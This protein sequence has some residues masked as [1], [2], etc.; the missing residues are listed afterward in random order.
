VAIVGLAAQ[1][2]S[3]RHSDQNLDRHTFWQFLLD[4][5]EAYEKL[6]QE[7]L[8]QLSGDII[9]AGG[10]FL[11]GTTKF[12]NVEFGASTKD[13]ASM[14]ASTRRMIELG[15]LAILDSGIDSRG[16]K[17]GTFIA[18]TNAEHFGVEDMG[19]RGF[20]TAPNTLANRVAY[21]LNVT[22]PSLYL[23]TA[24][25]STLTAMHLAIRS[26]ES[27]DCDAAIV[28]GCQHNMNF[29]DW[30]SYTDG[31][32]LTRDDKCKPF[33]ANADGFVKGEG[34]GTVVI[35]PLE[36]AIRDNDH[37]YGVIL[38]SAINSNGARAPLHAPSGV[39]Q[40]ECIR[41]AYAQAGRDPK[42]V[43]FVELHATGTAVGDPIEANAAGEL[44]ARDDEVI[45]GS[46]KGN[47][48]HLEVSAFF[49]SLLKIC[50]V[51]EN[52]VIPPNVHLNTPNPKIMW[53]KYGL[54]V[55]TEALPLGCRSSSGKSLVSLASSGIGGSNG[56]VVLESP[57]KV[58]PPALLLSTD[59]PVLFIVG[60]LSPRA[61]QEITNSVV[62][63]LTKDRSKEALSQAV[64]HARRARQ[65]PW[66]SYFICNPGS[67]MPPQIEGPVLIPK[68]RPPVAFVFTGQGPQH[69]GM[70]RHLF[71][72]YPVFRASILEMDEVYKAVT[73]VS[74]IETT[75]LFDDRY[76]T[77]LPAVWSVDI[78]IPAMTIMQIALFDLMISV[79]VKPDILVGHS[80][81]ETPMIY[82]S[83]AGSK[84]MAVEISIARGKAMKLTEPLGAGMAAVAC[85]VGRATVLIEQVKREEEGVL[86][87]ACHNSPDAIVVSGSNHL[88]DKAI[89]LAQD[90]GMFARKVQTLNP[91]HTSLMD[92]CRSE[93]EAGM[94]DIFQ[95]YAGSHKPVLPCYST[96][97]G[98]GRFIDEF[99]PEYCWS[100]VR[101]PVHFHQSISSILQDH[102]TAIFVEV[103]P[104]PTLSSYIVS[105]G[106]PSNMVT[107]PM[108]RPSK[109]SSGLHLDLIAFAESLGVMSTLG[110]NS[111]DLTS[112]YGRASRDPT[113]EIPYPFTT[114]HFPLRFD[115]PREPQT[116]VNGST[117]SLRVKMNAKLFP[118][119]AEHVI[120][121]EPIVPAAGFI[122]MVLQT[123]AKILWDLEFK[124]ILSLSSEVP[125]EARVE[126]DGS[127][128]ALK[129]LHKSLDAS[130]LKDARIHSS[131]FSS[132]NSPGEPAVFDIQSV[133][134]ECLPLI[135]MI[136]MSP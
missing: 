94:K 83:G 126:H 133:L 3:G 129:T 43:D 59:T 41:A 73:G 116:A 24:C 1:L 118:D 108:R 105:L 54:K 71:S 28:G 49:T 88:V 27:G 87:I 4:K 48:G 110:I 69:N 6:P 22:G 115:G 66:R 39:A 32:I 5:K 12:D 99:T 92:A 30:M 67:P 136:S 100:N 135:A 128:W 103:S 125:V 14:T 63:L 130:Q 107:C 112:L 58:D 75:G 51:L 122:D 56:H 45:I 85:G 80:A 11:K 61:A 86:D 21:T 96:V 93:Y 47:L 38:G 18:G 119:L 50:L 77:T 20:G 134:L 120:N 117:C 81:G 82:A 33:D 84:A 15:F 78:T 111:I 127:K 65:L 29:W 70:G 98:H 64:T 60:G 7:R 53:D 101:Q 91:A 19:S 57:P 25:S 13:V 10:T 23:D 62:E 72:A 104:H 109:K 106:V 123:G 17:I 132:S 9:P 31:G 76:P 124:S 74:L 44:F 102:P 113:F 52:K 37:I 131:G 55:P 16:K 68:V 8:E 90:E 95:R 36:D 2:P 40:Q 89:M 79:G 42:E 34:A 114:R 46:V 97:S 26:L 35:K 121:G